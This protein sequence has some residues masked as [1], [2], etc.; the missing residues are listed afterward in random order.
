MMFTGVDEYITSVSSLELFQPSI[1]AYSPLYGVVMYRPY[2]TVS[3]FGF[4]TY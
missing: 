4:S 2:P 3:N 1:S